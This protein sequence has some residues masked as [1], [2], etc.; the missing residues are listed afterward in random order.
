[1]EAYPTPL[2]DEFAADVFIYY[3]ETLEGYLRN[4]L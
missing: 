3:K 1:M 2:D 4:E